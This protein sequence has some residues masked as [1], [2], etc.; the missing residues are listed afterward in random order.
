MKNTRIFLGSFT[1]KTSKTPRSCQVIES[2][3]LLP[4]RILP[5]NNM[6]KKDKTR[7]T[8]ALDSNLK[9]AVLE[10]CKITVGS[11][12]KL[13][14]KETDFLVGMLIFFNNTSPL[15]IKSLHCTICNKRT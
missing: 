15:R 10:T 9:H 2:H 1:T 11:L 13:V 12:F 4:T 8:L 6:L 14:L 5:R 7:Q 3:I